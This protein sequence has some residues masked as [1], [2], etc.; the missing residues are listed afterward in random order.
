[1]H[2]L[3]SNGLYNLNNSRCYAVPKGNL[4][5]CG[6]ASYCMFFSGA[7]QACCGN[8]TMGLQECL[9]KNWTAAGM[10]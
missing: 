2:F 5:Y 8:C 6:A 4:R 7:Q 10:F 1:M 3:S 9:K